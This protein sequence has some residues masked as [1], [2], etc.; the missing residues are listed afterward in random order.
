MPNIVAADITGDTNQAITADDILNASSAASTDRPQIPLPISSDSLGRDLSTIQGLIYLKNTRFERPPSGSIVLVTV[1]TLQ[2]PD[3]VLGGAKFPAS[4]LPIRF[5][6]NE[7]NV[8]KE[9]AAVWKT[10]QT[11]DLLLQAEVCMQEDLQKTTCSKVFMRAVGAS[12]S[13]QLQTQ[14]GDGT[15]NVRAAASL[16]LEGI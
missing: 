1:R 3:V 9:Q 6:L 10:A 13:L 2:N 12:K 15:L 14:N 16:S 5:R 8:L 11:Q 7:Q 4:K